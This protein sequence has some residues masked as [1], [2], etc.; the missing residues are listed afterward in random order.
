MEVDYL[1]S[2]AGASG[3]AFLDTVFHESDATIAIVDRRDEPGGHWVDA[4]PFVN[5]HQP[6]S[7]YGVNS[8][9]L[10]ENR[11]ATSGINKGLPEVA[12]K[13]EILHYFRDLMDNVYLPSG[14]V[15]YLKNSE[16]L[17]DG[18]VRSLIS[19]EETVFTVR[20]KYVNAG[21]FGQHITIPATHERPFDVDDGVACA[22]LNDLPKIANQFEDFVV[23][24]AGKTAMDAV[25][26]LL[27]RGISTDH[28]TWVRPNDY[29]IFQRD[30]IVPHADYFD[31]TVNS[32][33]HEAESL[34]T[35]KTVE[36][37]CLRL[38]A[39]GRWQRIDR[40]YWPERFH[41]ATCSNAE[42]EA[43]R[44]IT[45]VVRLGRVKRI[46]TDKMECVKGDHPMTGAPLY[47]DCTG[48][49]EVSTKSDAKIFD[50]D[51]ITIMLVRPFQPVF[52]AALIAH[53]ECG[54]YNDTIR[55]FATQV[56]DFHHTPADYF[57]VQRQG[58]MNQ[59][60]WNQ[61]PAIRA[62]VDSSRLNA[63]TH[64]TANLTAEDTDKIA[65][66]KSFGPLMAQAVDNIPKMLAASEG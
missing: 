64:L 62:W 4:Y 45:D 66:L 48:A 58:F 35:S 6:S 15:T 2:G 11:L 32:I 61:N 27:D 21:F 42:L 47:V 51:T 5:L 3:L 20:K 25:L 50:G 39:E 30:V 12:S 17:G 16:H 60:L 7:F 13:H 43:L 59:Y 37:H 36:E 14:R 31:A 8:K 41:A 19:G 18:V 53:L 26:W 55:Q 29:W 1:I 34:A 46:T 24:G 57:A 10:G 23:L 49:A 54:D 33:K 9:P 38:E 56:T 28:I 63:G 40:D 52:S 44:T 65:L 22:P